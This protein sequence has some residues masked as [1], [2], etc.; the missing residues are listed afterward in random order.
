MPNLLGMY[1]HA[2]RL[3]FLGFL[4]LAGLAPPPPPPPPPAGSGGTDDGHAGGGAAN[5]ISTGTAGR[6]VPTVGTGAANG[7]HDQIVALRWVQ[8]N[9]RAFGGDPDQ[10]TVAGESGEG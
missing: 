8:K 3:G 1:T 7:L 9:I 6:R 4:N 2:D 10:V 5:S